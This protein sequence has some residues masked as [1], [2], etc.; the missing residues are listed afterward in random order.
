M[1]KMSLPNWAKLNSCCC[2]CSLKDGTIVIGGLHLCFSLILLV[3]AIITLT[4]ELPGEL[5]EVLKFGPVGA[6]IIKKGLSIGGGIF[7]GVG[8]IA[9]IVDSCL[10]H[11]ARKV[12]WVRVGEQRCK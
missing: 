2:G 6:D 9:V 1:A 8:I 10:I 7:L 5:L 4:T 11:G 12:R 3:I